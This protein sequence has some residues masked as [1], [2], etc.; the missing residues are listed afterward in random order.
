A[1]LVNFA[2]DLGERVARPDVRVVLDGELRPDRDDELTQLVRLFALPE[3]LDGRVELLLPILDDGH[4][5]TAGG[6]V[7]LLAHRLVL[8]DVDELHLALRVGHDGLRI[9]IPAEEEV[10]GFDDLAFL[11]RERGAVR[12]GEAAAD[13]TLGRLEQDLALSRGD[14]P[15]LRGRL[16]RRHALEPDHAVELRLALRLGRDARRR[17]ADVERA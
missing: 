5:A 12:N 14:D 4:L 2:A 10:A 16:H 1:R 9:R 3:D 15:L 11:D 6:L 13:G 7:E 17:A 8:D